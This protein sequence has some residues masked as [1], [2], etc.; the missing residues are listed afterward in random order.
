MGGNSSK[1]KA[2][3]RCPHCAFS[4]ASPTA[5]GS[6]WIC[7]RCHGRVPDPKATT[8]ASSSSSSSSSSKAL[9]PLSR[10]AK[11]GY[12][13]LSAQDDDSASSSSAAAAAAAASA[14]QLPLDRIDICPFY[15][16][17]PAEHQGIVSSINYE[18]EMLSL[19]L[20]A[21]FQAQA[22]K[23][24]TPQGLTL[25][26]G[27]RLQI[28]SVDWKVL[29][30]Y[31]PLGLVTPRTSIRCMHKPLSAIAQIVKMHV[32][33]VWATLPRET[34]SDKQIEVKVPDANELFRQYIRPWIEEGVA[35]AAA[36]GAAAAP[37]AASSS[38]S[39]SSSSARASSSASSSASAAA[40]ALDH[41]PKHIVEG[42]LFLSRGVQFKIVSCVPE[43]GLITHDTEIFSNGPPLADI[44]K[45]QIHPLYESLPNSEK[46]WTGSQLFA[47]YL[48]PYFQGRFRYVRLKDKLDI[49]GVEFRITACEPLHGIVTVNSLIFNDGPPLRAEDLRRQQ[50]IEDEQMARQM[51][52]AEDAASRPPQMMFM[53]QRGGP[54]MLQRPIQVQTPEELRARLAA[55]LRMMPPDDPHREVV[56][57]LYDQLG[58]LPPNAQLHSADRGMLGML[59][60]AQP[61]PNRGASAADIEALPTRT[62]HAPPAKAHPAG[63]GAATGSAAA[64]SDEKSNDDVENERVTCMVRE[65][66]HSRS[67]CTGGPGGI[68]SL[69]RLVV[70]LFCAQVCLSQYEEGD[71]LRTLPCFH[72]YH[73]VSSSNSRQHA[74][75]IVWLARKPAS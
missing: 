48:L 62:Y 24:G 52:Q 21:F 50:E 32:L 66:A 22:E 10:S 26:V 71:E 60:A 16:T 27:S 69:T 13:Q 20:T 25:S 41:E 15:E 63:A 36:S 49:D 31:P 1:H 38:S 59:R 68:H 73:R 57:R 65:H 55:V 23:A 7:A 18:V 3:P 29:G 30:C 11:P 39:S 28:N 8:A 42:D 17:L 74:P 47:K 34:N 19:Y 9:N 40:S 14:E 75:G 64:S 4:I 56:E 6:A 58:Q 5:V 53:N 67:V 35:A 54:V 45:L 61:E 70:L 12:G 2:D 43:N 37:A 33:P 72:S 51:Q 44:Q 46:A